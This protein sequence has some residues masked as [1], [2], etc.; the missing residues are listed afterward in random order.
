[1]KEQRACDHSLLPGG[2]V[3]TVVNADCVHT[4][5]QARFSTFYKLLTH[6]MLPTDEDHVI[7]RFQSR[8][9]IGQSRNLPQPVHDGARLR[10]RA[11][12]FLSPPADPLP[13]G[14]HAPEKLSRESRTHSPACKASLGMYE[15]GF[16]C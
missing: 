2:V 6:L 7:A 1:M 8:R 11:A 13:R 5:C 3:S 10:V 15:G 16:I 14:A 9:Q 12:W 4:L